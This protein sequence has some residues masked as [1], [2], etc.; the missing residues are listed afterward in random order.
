MNVSKSLNGAPLTPEQNSL[1]LEETMNPGR[2]TFISNSLAAASF[3]CLMPLGACMGTSTKKQPV[4]FISGVV[5]NDLEKM[6]WREVLKKAA[7]MGYTEYEGQN[8]GESLPEFK[9]YC[10]T[11]GIKHIAGS[12]PFV[13]DM[14]AV[15]TK[16]DELQSLGVP[17]TVCYYPWL[18][19]APFTKADCEQSAQLL[20]KIG[21][22]AN[23]RGIQLCWHN[24]EKEFIPMENGELPFDYLMEHTAQDLVSLELDLYWATNAGADP[25]QII[26]TLKDRIKMLHVKDMEGGSNQEIT[27]VG[28]GTINF[29]TLLSAAQKVG[30]EHFIVERDR[31]IN[32]LECLQTAFDHLSGLD[33]PNK[34]S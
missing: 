17:Y 31:A 4:G 29:E 26:N 9:E 13:E 32:G 16:L 3:A 21:K 6:D 23:E 25:L 10:A 19:Q 8:L 22:L 12:V 18:V 15:T 28:K 20:N 24:H 27:C 7:D 2:R 34:V 11:L 14:E 30:I 33:L 5:K 1:K